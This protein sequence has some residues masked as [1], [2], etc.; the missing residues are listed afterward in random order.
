M[1]YKSLSQER[2]FHA[3]KAAMMKKGVDISEWDA[4]SKGKQLPEKVKQKTILKGKK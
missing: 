4:D 3:N 2:F 1:P